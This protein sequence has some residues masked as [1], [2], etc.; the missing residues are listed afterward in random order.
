MQT[1]KLTDY[2]TACDLPLSDAISQ[3]VADGYQL[4]THSDPVSDGQTDAAEWYALDLPVM[5]RGPPA[6]LSGEE[7]SNEIESDA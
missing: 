3:A 5:S 1:I 2:A 6:I 4:N 7:I